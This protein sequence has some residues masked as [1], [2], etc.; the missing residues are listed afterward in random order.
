[1][2]LVHL[3]QLGLIALALLPAAL[4]ADTLSTDGVSTCLTGSQIEVKKLHITYSR[5]SREVVFDVGGTN[6]KEQN[7]TAALSVT[8]YGNEVYNKEFD[9]CSADNH[10]DQLCPGTSVVT[11]SKRSI[12]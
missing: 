7:V 12:S 5:T 4:A 2:R 3:S 9:P 8:A 1:M 11:P 6:Q 10:V